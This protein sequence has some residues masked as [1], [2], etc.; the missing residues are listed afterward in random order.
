MVPKMLSAETRGR[1]DQL[2]RK[3]PRP[4]SALIPALKLAQAETGHLSDAVVEELSGIF[5]LP[6]NE[7]LAVAS[8]YTMLFKKPVGKHVIWVCTNISCLL[9][10]SDAIMK[11]LEEKLGIRPGETTSDRRFTLFEA[12]CLASCGTAPAAQID[13][14]YYE[15][16]TPEKLDR[17]LDSLD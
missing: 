2:I 17:I 3:Y 4:R 9:C 5:D 7:I 16:L 12:E 15:D 1:I 8:F 10:N 14:D 11:H 13:D 6:P